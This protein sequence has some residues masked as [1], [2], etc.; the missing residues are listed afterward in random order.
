MATQAWRSVVEMLTTVTVD[1]YSEE[2]CLSLEAGIEAVRNSLPMHFVDK[3]AHINLH[4]TMGSGFTYAMLHCLLHCATIMVHRRRLLHFIQTEGFKH[5]TWRGVPHL[6]AQTVDRVFAASHTVV[7]LLLALESNAEKDSVP[8]FPLV[9][10]FSCFTACATVAWF[11]LKGLT[12][13]DINETAEAI[14]SDGMRFLQDGASTWMLAVPWYRHLSVMAKVLQNGDR[15]MG[16]GI[17]EPAPPSIKDDT[18]SQPDNSLESMDYVR[19]SSVTPQE[20]GESNGTEPPRNTSTNTSTNTSANPGGLNALQDTT[21][22]T[23]ADPDCVRETRETPSD[24]G[25]HDGHLHLHECDTPISPGQ[26]TAGGWPSFGDHR[27]R[28]FGRS[29]RRRTTSLTQSSDPDSYHARTPSSNCSSYTGPSPPGCGQRAAL[30]VTAA[31]VPLPASQ[32]TPALSSS[33]VF[34][35]S[36]SPRHLQF[37]CHPG[38]TIPRQ[39]YTPLIN[40]YGQDP[41]YR[42]STHQSLLVSPSVKPLA[43][44]AKGFGIHGYQGGM[45]GFS[46]LNKTP[47]PIQ[48]SISGDMPS[49]RNSAS[50]SQSGVVASNETLLSSSAERGGTLSTT[51][52][53]ASITSKAPATQLRGPRAFVVR[54]GRTYINEATLPYPLP[55]DLP[56]LHRQSLRTLLMFQLFGGPILS[57]VFASRPPTRVLDVGCGAGFWSM[58]CHR[59]FA[60][61]GHSS[62]SFTGLD[63]VPLGGSG[64]QT[65]VKPDKEMQWHF[66]QHDIRQLPWPFADGEFDLVMVKD[67]AFAASARDA[68]PI[69]D[70]YLRVLKPGGVLEFWEVD[71][72]IRMLRP[73]APKSTGAEIHDDDTSSDGGD[74]EDNAERMGA[75]VMNNNTPI[76]PPQNPYVVDYNAWSSKALEHLG[77]SAAPCT[78]IGPSL[79]QE[80]ES[81]M[82]VQSKRLAVPLSEIKWEREGVGGVVT[83]DGKSYIDTQKGKFRDTDWKTGSSV[84]AAQSALRRTALE[85]TVSFILALEPLLRDVSGKSQEEWDTWA[86]KM[87]NDLLRDDGTSWG[88]CLE[89]GVWTARKRH[90]KS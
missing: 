62:I 41:L 25:R 74:D 11:S 79:L 18:A 39:N 54:N 14:V 53:A 27:P 86:G 55:V 44:P 30:Q 85:T 28:L 29:A 40:L 43:S 15:D 58:M 1:T 84:T 77:L 64:A 20:S 32:P 69:M 89:V 21:A 4:I 59:Y 33:P 10:L 2:Q 23:S 13:A 48:H 61:H 68:Q 78:S 90:S 26:S 52:V 47:Y 87:T 19:H 35:L 36:D 8:N 34:I 72:I 9:M 12:P 24:H 37:N 45:P 66:V 88:E 51:S 80:A 63:I 82:D 56:E 46:A 42:N 65:N 75:Y 3:P 50:T 5:E 81:L 31:I 83:K 73:H 60:Q 38:D 49:P 76:S 7:S 6:H 71:S 57:S 22:P 70:E 67:M 16:R 17:T